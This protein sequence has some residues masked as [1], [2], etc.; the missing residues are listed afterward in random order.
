MQTTRAI[1]L[2][3]NAGSHVTPTGAKPLLGTLKQ[4]GF[5]GFTMDNINVVFFMP[6]A[7]SHTQPC[8]M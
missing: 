6:N 8:D 4:Y 2:T 5:K 7:T 1:L 3:D